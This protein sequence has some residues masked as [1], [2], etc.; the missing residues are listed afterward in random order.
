MIILYKIQ[1]L[2]QH[3]VFGSLLCYVYKQELAM[4][5]LGMDIKK[6]ICLAVYKSF[7]LAAQQNPQA[8]RAAQLKVSLNIVT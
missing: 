4:I 2:V 7:Q 1:W 6:E 3:D 8:V 5:R